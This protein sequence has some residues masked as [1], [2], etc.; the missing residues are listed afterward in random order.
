[1]KP[2]HFEKK[3]SLKKVT[4]SNLKPGEMRD[5]KGADGYTNPA[6]NTIEKRCFIYSC[7]NCTWPYC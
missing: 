4:L 2:K 3:L 5:A 7:V 6:W 1:M